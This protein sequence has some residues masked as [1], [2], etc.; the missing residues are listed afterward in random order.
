MPKC[1]G[2]TCHLHYWQNDRG[3]LR[4][5]AITRVWNGHRIRVSTQSWPWG[6]K[7][8]RHSC[9]D[10][11]SQPF[12]NESGPLTNKLSRLPSRLFRTPSVLSKHSWQVSYTDIEVPVGSPSRGGD[13]A[14]DVFD[15]KQLSLPTPFNSLVVS[16][17]VFMALSAVFHSDNSPLSHSVFPV[18]FLPYW[19]F[20]LYFFMKV[21]FSPDTFLCGWLGLKHQLTK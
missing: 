18:F 21:S 13:V 5:T 7:F 17:S 20:Q 8:S 6:R 16:V 3:L 15:I 2:V 10:S 12:D 11:I 19:S 1:L 9:R 14:V 4:A